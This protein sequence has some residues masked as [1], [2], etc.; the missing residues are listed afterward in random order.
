MMDIVQPVF[1]LTRAAPAGPVLRFVLCTDK[2]Q[3]QPR[4]NTHY[5]SK[6][7]HTRISNHQERPLEQPWPVV[8]CV[9]VCSAQCLSTSQGKHGLPECHRP[10]AS[11]LRRK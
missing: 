8:Q 11:H 9:C 4:T 3:R 1:S 2:T 6:V 5:S 10:G 7:K